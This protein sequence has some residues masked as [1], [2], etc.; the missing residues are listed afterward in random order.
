MPVSKAVIPA[1]DTGVR[2]YP[3][4]RSQPKEMLPLGR[5]P[6]V[7]VVIEEL[8]GA[9]ITD[10]CMVTGER[11]RA[12]EDHFD[13]ASEMAAGPDGQLFPE[14]LRN[15]SV[16]IFY[17][18]QPEPK[19]LGDALLHTEAFVGDEAFVLALGDVV[20]WGTAGEGVLMRRMAEII[21]AT[22]GDGVLGVRQVRK[23]QVSDHCIVEPVGEIGAQAHFAVAD[24]MD[25]PALGTALSDIA[26]AGRYLLSPMIFD[27]LKE[28]PRTAEGELRLPDALR[29]M[30]LD[31][32][33]VWA[34]LMDPNDQAYDVGNFLQYSRAFLRFSLDDPE[35]GVAVREYIERMVG[36]G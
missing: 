18:R 14:A 36:D 30:T 15:G 22:Q 6:A 12:I 28:T 17:V 2:L 34:V 21:E 35:V 25:R 23:T 7:Q 10:I 27:Y 20:I 32:E 29:R 1:V 31:R 11:S 4:T 24:L 8:I 3:L 9:G 26:V 13:A 16:H 33:S 19:G 5:K